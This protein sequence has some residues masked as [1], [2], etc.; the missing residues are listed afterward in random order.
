[1]LIFWSTTVMFASVTWWSCYC[2]KSPLNKATRSVG[3][4]S[5]AL[6]PTGMQSLPVG[7][8]AHHTVCV[9]ICVCVCMRD[10]IYRQLLHYLFYLTINWVQL[11]CRV[12]LWESSLK[13]IRSHISATPTTS[14]PWVSDGT[15]QTFKA[16]TFVWWLVWMLKISWNFEAP[17]QSSWLR[18]FEHSL[19][20]M[21]IAP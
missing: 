14:V 18:W 19:R 2:L 11:M 16:L 6:K 1:M 4:C 12:N 13:L 10:C 8:P 7:P 20:I 3:V 9:F 5:C 15:L 17:L 21:C